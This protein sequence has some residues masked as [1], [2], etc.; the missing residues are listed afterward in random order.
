MDKPLQQVALGIGCDG[1][2]LHCLDDVESL[3]IG[4]VC[5][6]ILFGQ[7]RAQAGV[8]GCVAGC[9]TFFVPQLAF[10]LAAQIGV[11]FYAIQLAHCVEDYDDCRFGS[12][13]GDG[14][15]G[16]CETC[17]MPWQTYVFG[18]AGWLLGAVYL[19]CL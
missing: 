10:A 3:V 18:L 8:G 17:T 16:G 5:P 14:S 11:F 12:A 9:L 19:C 1:S 7:T 15:D 4:L 6:A 13:S 2:L